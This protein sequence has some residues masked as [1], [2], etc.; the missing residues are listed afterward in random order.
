M[1][2]APES[3]SLLPESAERLAA[4][5]RALQRIDRFFET[6]PDRPTGPQL[7][8]DEIQARLGAFDFAE[9]LPLSSAIDAAA[10]L[11]EAGGLHCGHP[12]YLG[13]F[14]PT[15][16]Y[17]GVVADLLTAAYNPNLACWTHAPAAVEIEAHAIATVAGL[18]GYRSEERAG[19]FTTGGAEANAT[20]LYCALTRACPAYAEVGVGAFEGT[21]VFY[22]SADS[23][24]AWL[25]IAHQAGVG[26]N[27][28]RLVP[29]DG[30]G[31]LD[32]EALARMVQEDRAAGRRPVMAAA[33]AGA[34]GSGVIDPLPEI[35]ALARVE[36]LYFHVDAAWGGAALFSRS[37][38]ACLAGIEQADS[39]TLD[40]HKWLAVPMG[41]GMFLARD[42][43]L[44]ARTFAVS[45]SYM[46]P[47]ATELDGYTHSIQWSR[48][49]IGLKLF[50]ALAQLGLGGYE[51]MVD[52]QAKLGRLLRGRLTASGW[53]CV[54]ETPLPVV[55]FEKPGLDLARLAAEVV[56][57]DSAWIST[58][59]FEGRTVLRACVSGF[60]TGKADIAA[61]CDLIE[62]SAARQA[63]GND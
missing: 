15:P 7:S 13:L 32:P 20:A 24:L 51:A 27:A 33:T 25:K 38:R 16:A 41:A 48:R 17:A 59:A 11:L 57:G 30:A 14:N 54:N 26:R 61:V 39:V 46:P 47:G 21:P 4:G 52:R 5:A 55:C 3:R 19:H 58:T 31:R 35:A 18:V 10:D 12:R 23:H 62:A 42:R 43:S 63:T 56:A 1:F 28:L 60:R 34:T 36:G 44:L 45:T 53:A 37:L 29:T 2:I 50:L 40:A 49:F 22:A 8:R 6:L 9:P